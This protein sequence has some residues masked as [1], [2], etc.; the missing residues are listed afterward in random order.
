MNHA[1]ADQYMDQSN[2]KSTLD[3]AEREALLVGTRVL[4]Y[5]PQPPAEC[6]KLYQNWKGYFRI[7]RQ[8]DHYC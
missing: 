8:V 2:S 7:K 4:V 1:I 5:H 3:A 6:G